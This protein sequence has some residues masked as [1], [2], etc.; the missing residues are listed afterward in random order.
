MGIGEADPVTGRYD[1]RRVVPGHWAQPEHMWQLLELLG[2][3]FRR[4]EVLPRFTVPLRT[5]NGRVGLSEFAR[6]VDVVW[7]ACGVY[8]PDFHVREAFNRIMLLQNGG[9][10]AVVDIPRFM[11]RGRERA[12]MYA[13]VPAGV[14]VDGHH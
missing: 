14:T 1:A 11:H 13:I 5:C 9:S 4:V 10:I 7:Q 8:V 12:N 2:R 6:L 3:E